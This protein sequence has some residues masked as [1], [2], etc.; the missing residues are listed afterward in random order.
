MAGLARWCYQHRIVVVVLWVVGLLGLGA[1]GTAAGNAYNDSF[2]LPGTESTKALDL[3]Q[4]AFPDAAG[5]S[6]TIVWHAKSGSVKDADVTDRINGMLKAVSNAPSVASVTSP[7]TPEGAAQISKDGT[8]A[9]ATVTFTGQLDDLNLDDVDKVIQTAEKARTDGLDVELGGNA[10]QQVNQAPPGSSEAYGIAAAAVILLIAFGSL[11]AMVIPLITAVLALAVGTS[12]IILLSHVMT[13][14]T[15][16]PTVAALIGLGVGIDYALFV[17]TRHRNGLMAGLSVEESAVRALNTSG[18]A[19]VFAG[20]TVCI[21]LLGMLVLGLTFLTGIGVAASV[22]VLFSVASAITLLPALLGF[23]GTRVLSRRERKRLAAEGPYEAHTRGFWARWAGIVQRRPRM[24]A[25]I[26]ILLIA[27]LSIPTLSLR[28]GSSDQGNDPADS[29]TRKAYDL[30]ADGFG[31]GSNGPLQLV[32]ELKSPGDTA[33]LNELVQRVQDEK[34]VAAVVA[35]PTPPGADLGIVQVIPTTSPQSEETSNLIKHLREDVVP[36]VEQGNT[37]QVYVGGSTAIF[38]DFADVLTGKLPL[39]LGVIIALGFLLLMVAFRSLLVPLTA[40]I[41][42]VL[43]AAA[44]FGVI[45]AVFQWGWGADA[46]NIGAAGPVEAFL[47]VMMLAI[48][49]G[50][51]MDYQVFLVSRMHEE[52]VHTGDNRRAVTVGQASTGRVITAA[53]TIMIF[54]FGAFIFEGQRVIAEFGIGLS[55]AV[56][57]DAFILRTLLVPALMHWFGAG[58][59]WIPKWLDRWLPHLTVEPADE[60][61]Q[62]ERPEEQREPVPVG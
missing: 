55:S 2:A 39:F 5:E 62:P 59:W 21:A 51:S 35:L 9:Y 24:L 34:G 49:F 44:S 11:L 3:L 20:I 14:G 48:L 37:I 56:F 52:W 61:V 19:V 8:I 47:P 60:P 43:A 36:D 46:L 18:R 6:D 38:D 32:A 16:A 15:I 50:L 26:A 27:V 12:S 41:M 23:F 42:N 25:G 10:I 7:Y 40:A 30:L 29:T 33:A 53:A 58:N 17:V 4:K 13:I 31:P 22:V 57:I 28:L 54:V 45:V 1:A